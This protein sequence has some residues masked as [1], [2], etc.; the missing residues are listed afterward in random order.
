MIPKDDLLRTVLAII[1]IALAL[2]ALGGCSSSPYAGFEEVP[3]GTYTIVLNVKDDID[4]GPS[5]DGTTTSMGQYHSIQSKPDF[6]VIVHEIA[7]IFFKD[8]HEKYYNE[9]R[10]NL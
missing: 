6:C 1:C 4:K 9:C 7:H 10:D 2:L 8:Y 3:K 5:Y